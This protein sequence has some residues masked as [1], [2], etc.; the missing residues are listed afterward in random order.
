VFEAAAVDELLEIF[1]TYVYIR[2]LDRACGAFGDFRAEL[3]PLR[4]TL[5]AKFELAVDASRTFVQ[6]QLAT[7][8]RYYSAQIARVAERG[9]RGEDFERGVEKLRSDFLRATQPPA[10]GDQIP[11]LEDAKSY[12]GVCHAG[13]CSNADDV[14]ACLRVC[15]CTAHRARQALTADQLATAT[16]EVLLSDLALKDPA[17]DPRFRD[18]PPDA[19]PK[20]LPPP[21]AADIAAANVERDRILSG[22]VLALK[23]SCRVD[24]AQGYGRDG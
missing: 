1:Q 21:T 6:S 17:F 7:T 9:C 16:N 5:I 23:N 11:T 18:L 8:D 10:G 3:E 20:A 4:E 14:R 22:P 19:R 12:Y 2:D 24:I 13:A 15:A